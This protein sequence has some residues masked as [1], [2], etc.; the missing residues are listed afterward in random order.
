MSI[1]VAIVEDNTTI[2]NYLADI[3][4]K[5]PL[6]KLE[7]TANTVKSAQ[8][9]IS[10]KKIDVFLIDLGLPDGSGIEII[11][12]ALKANPLSKCLVLS[13][14]GDLSHVMK[15]LEAGATGYIQKGEMP[16]DIVS[17]I[18]EIF[19]DTSPLSSTIA[20]LLIRK[21][22]QNQV[23]ENIKLNKDHQ[24][25]K[26]F[27]IT[28]REIEVLN[29]I[30]SDLSIKEIAD[31]LDLSKHTVNQHLRNI[32]AKLGV[33]SRLAAINLVKKYIFNES[34]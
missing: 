24:L 7:G 27:G 6:C 11:K 23:Q 1:S 32:Y 31:S 9:L 12:E 19:N 15:S 29:A 14:F 4:S 25:S 26:N 18:V 21:I 30:T 16:S 13:T 2:C 28:K 8:N 5:S 17:K 3:V 33:N 34:I 20:K 10:S 22:T